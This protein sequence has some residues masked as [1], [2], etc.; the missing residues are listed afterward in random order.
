MFSEFS[1]TGLRSHLVDEGNQVFPLS[2]DYDVPEVQHYDDLRAD[3][4]PGHSLVSI[5]YSVTSG[6]K[7]Y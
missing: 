5:D 7:Y 3:S 2:P 6:Y 4:M 1:C